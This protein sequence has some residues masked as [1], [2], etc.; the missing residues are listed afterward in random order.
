MAT[1]PTIRLTEQDYL[2]IDR[3]AEHKSEYVD[4]EMYAMSGGSLRHSRLAVRL[5]VVLENQFKRAAQYLRA[6][7]AFAPELL[8]VWM[9]LGVS[10]EDLLIAAA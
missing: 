3:A 2:T 5:I 7:L 9:I 4:G 8:G 6:Q 10:E 1:Q